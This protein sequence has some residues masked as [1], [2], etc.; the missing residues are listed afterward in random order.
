MTFIVVLAKTSRT[1]HTVLVLSFC[2][3]RGWDGGLVPVEPF[4]NRVFSSPCLIPKPQ[5]ALRF[6]PNTSFVTNTIC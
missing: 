4:R 6:T 1:P 3:R 2:G 5:T